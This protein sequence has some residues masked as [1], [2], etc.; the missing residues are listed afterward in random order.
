M[1]PP[2]Q[3]PLLLL[4]LTTGKRPLSRPVIVPA[5]DEEEDEDEDDDAEDECRLLSMMT[6]TILRT[7]RSIAWCC[8]KPNLRPEK[9]LCSYK[10]TYCAHKSG[11]SPGAVKGE[12]GERVMEG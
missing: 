11:L 1:L 7:M 5:P 8:T 12:G 4:L 3:P 6:S 10:A 2:P 9:A